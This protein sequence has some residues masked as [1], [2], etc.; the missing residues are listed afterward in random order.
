MLRSVGAAVG[1]AVL[2]IVVDGLDRPAVERALRA[3]LDAAC[4]PGVVEISA[5]NYVGKLGKHHF[6]LHALLST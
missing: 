3:G 4:R 1:A 2:E 6:H 5:G